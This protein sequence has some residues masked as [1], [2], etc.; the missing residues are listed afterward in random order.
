M[1]E[2]TEPTKEELIQIVKNIQFLSDP[3]R[4]NS[5]I[6]QAIK[7]ISENVTSINQRLLKIEEKLYGNK[8]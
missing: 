8:E 5:I 2:E 1:P 3:V 7:D 6:Y 4:Y